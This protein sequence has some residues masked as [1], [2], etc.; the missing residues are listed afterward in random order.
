VHWVFIFASL[1]P[2][3]SH[4]ACRKASARLGSLRLSSSSALS[5][6]LRALSLDLISGFIGQTFQTN[7]Y[8]TGEKVRLQAI[9]MRYSHAM[10]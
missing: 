1:L 10:I 5:C 4:L 3:H 7:R 2:R 6:A 8:Q 9:A